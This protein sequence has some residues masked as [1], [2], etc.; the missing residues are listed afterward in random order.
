MG[1]QYLKTDDGVSLAYQVAE[2][3]GP[4]LVY[5][6]GAIS[7]LT[8]EDQIPEFARFFERL[9]RFARVIRFDKRG[10]GTPRA[11]SARWSWA[12]PTAAWWP[13]TSRSAIPNGSIA[14]S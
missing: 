11:P 3:D 13:P 2:G 8:L 6:S 10:T 12:P 14:S 9:T 1:T 5:I 4:T 7:N